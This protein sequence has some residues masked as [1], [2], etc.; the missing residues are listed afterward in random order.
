MSNTENRYIEEDEIDL[1]ELFNTIIKRKWFIVV[2]TSIVT[3]GA[4]IWALTRTPIY[5][6]RA[7]IEIGNYK[8]H[9]NNN[10]NNNVLLDN[11]S[12]LTQKLNILFIDME[13]NIKGKD[14]TINSI[15]IPKGS[16]EFV[17]IKALSISNELAKNEI[18]KV[19]DYIEV[20]HQKI[21]DDTKQRRELEI[22]NIDININ[23]IKSIQL[24]EY[25]KNILKQEYN[26][27]I[28]IEELNNINNIIKKIET[29]DYSL[30]ALKL[31]EKTNLLK[32]ISDLE[33]T[34]FNQKKEYNDLSISTLND[35]LEK[36]NIMESLLLPHNYKNTQIVGEIITNDYPI[37]PKKKLIVT[38]AFVTGF[39][40]SIFLVF[41]LE[42]I[43]NMRKEK[44]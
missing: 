18:N 1:R 24:K 15:K 33:L 44:E 22:K 41:F 25:K 38:V 6:A 36:K 4:I 13:K 16:N 17:E 23:N 2:F 3:I 12:Q 20:K 21:L 27:K 32:M 34:L 11:A 9:N 40:L 30:T 28:Y 37:K 7:L 10:N 43:T 8:M 5:E 35:L 14:A 42:F 31:M 29:V 39:I 26:L 19:I